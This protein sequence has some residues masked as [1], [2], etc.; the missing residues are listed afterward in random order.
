M[1]HRFFEQSWLY[2]KGQNSQ[3]RFEEF[4]LLK[5]QFQYLH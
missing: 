5:F 1:I 4:L 3:F 2:Y